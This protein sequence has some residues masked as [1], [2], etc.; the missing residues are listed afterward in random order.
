MR[1]VGASRFFAR[2]PFVVEGIIYGVISAIFALFIS[3]TVVYN[4][5]PYLN[6]IFIL[7]LNKYFSSNILEIAII[8]ILGGIILGFIATYLA[9]AKYLKV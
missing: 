8:L 7:D 3:W 1:L 4:I 5:S 2:G 6:E 9:V